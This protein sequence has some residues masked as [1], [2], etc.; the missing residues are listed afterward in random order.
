MSRGGGRRG[1]KREE[2]EGERRRKRERDGPQ[3]ES[4]PTDRRDG[5]RRVFVVRSFPTLRTPDSL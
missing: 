4:E 5:C 2:E 3:Q 1:K